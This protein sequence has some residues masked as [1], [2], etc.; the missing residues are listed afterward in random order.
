MLEPFWPNPPPALV[1]IFIRLFGVD[2][3]LKILVITFGRMWPILLD[4]RDRLS[5]PSSTRFAELRAQVYSQIHRPREGADAAA[6]V[7]P[8]RA[9]IDLQATSSPDA[10]ALPGLM[11]RAPAS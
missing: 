10:G 11:G 9:T 6:G 1:P 7:A 5:T 8:G 2:D 4:E 3:T